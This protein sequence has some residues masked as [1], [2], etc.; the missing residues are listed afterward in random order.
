MISSLCLLTLLMA[1]PERDN[2][3]G[4]QAWAKKDTAAALS[5]FDKAERADTAQS[6]YA[7]NAGTLKTIA[8]K[9]GES[10]FAH[11]LETAKDRDARA[12][13]LYNRGTAR[14]HKAMT[15]PPGQADVGGAVSDLRDAL[16]L[17]PGW[18]EASHNLDRALRLRPPP[19]KKP[20]QKPKDQPKDQKPQDKKDPQNKPGDGE[21]P[22][23]EQ[24]QNPTPS[25]MDPR[26]AQRLMDGAAAR[27]AQ[28][29]R[30]KT[31]KPQEESDAPDW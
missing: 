8:G 20:D 9:D 19:Q 1:G 16:K 7:F 27:E 6:D 23:P 21:K 5:S 3:R 30:E 18:N 31:R 14:L 25:G 11:A 2:H 15:S 26:D 10:D 13:T 22:P 4:I 29:A 28:Q 12:R 24:G 17:K